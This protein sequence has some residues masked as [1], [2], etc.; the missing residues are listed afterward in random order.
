[1]AVYKRG[2]QR[3]QGKFEGRWTRFLVMP[4]FS[5]ERM[6]RQRL[7]FLF[8]VAAMV[9]PLLCVAYVYLSNN[10][11]LLKEIPVAGDLL[12]ISDGFFMTFMSVQ[13]IFAVFLAALTGPGL[14]APDLTNNALA[15]YFSRPL[16]RLD[17]VTGKLAALTG[18][19]S[20]ITWIPGLAVF[21][22]QSAMAGGGWGTANLR[23]GVGL[24]AGFLLWIFLVALVALTS[25]AWVK[26]RVIA[27]GLVLG[28]F[29]VFSGISAMV[30]GIF[31]HTWGY[32]LD[33]SWLVNRMVHA[34]VGTD[35]PDVPDATA[36][37]SAF[38]VILF[39]FV[40]ILERKLR[41]VEVVS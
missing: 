28:F 15:L 10:A 39:L 32:L 1:M 14:I 25:S 31:R 33:P 19:L 34:I 3:Y 21:F 36:A 17:Y 20:L 41:P 11:E 24:F 8:L 13:K 7:V 18:L 37:V 9:W 26:L 29:F 27:G 6:F 23:L 4:R 38:F 12:E 30:N 16:T 22:M 2:Y 40:L 35:T 5:W